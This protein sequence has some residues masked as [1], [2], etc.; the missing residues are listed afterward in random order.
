[1]STSN[2]ET[3]LYQ[4]LRED[5]ISGELKP[6]VPLVETTLAEQYHTS[7]T[8]IREALLRLTQDGLVERADR[9]LR[10][11]VCSPEE[12]LEIYEV[13]TVLEAASA[14]G[15]AEHHTALDLLR[16]RNSVDQMAATDPTDYTAMARANLNFHQAMWAASHNATLIDMLDRL[17]SRL[18]RYPETTLSF[19]GRWENAL[20]EHKDMVTAI[21][22]RDS[23]KASQIASDHMT[24]ARDIRLRMFSENQDGF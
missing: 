9:G 10:V 8:P 1:M 24:E 17:N 22:Q 2:T 7:R 11:R 21:A 6:G 19:P 12:I 15:A 18:G 5:I 23:S 14:R 4:Q 13:R 20:S 3:N 16:L